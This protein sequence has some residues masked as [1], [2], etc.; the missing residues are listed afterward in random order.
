MKKLNILFVCR[1]NRFRSRVAEAYFKKINKNK[2]INVKSAGLIRG[3]PIKRETIDSVKKFGLNISGKPN[4]LT[5]E[6]MAWQ[7]VTVVVANNVP[8]QVFDRNK[9]YGKKVIVWKIKDVEKGRT[10]EMVAQ[11]IMKKVDQ[12]NKNL[13]RLK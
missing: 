2:N 9:R 7:N 6:V 3:V 11:E 4:G 10:K 13:E 12:L 1:Y 8:P 5:S